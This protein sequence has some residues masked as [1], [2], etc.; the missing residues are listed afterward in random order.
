MPMDRQSYQFSALVK[1]PVSSKNHEYRT[2]HIYY[3]SNSSYYIV[4]DAFSY[5][6][7]AFRAR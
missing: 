1:I 7:Y 4:S 3:R 6:R 5:N 2:N